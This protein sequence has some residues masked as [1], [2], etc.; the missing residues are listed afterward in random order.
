MWFTVVRVDNRKQLNNMKKATFFLL[1]TSTFC[2]SQN[3]TELKKLD[4]ILKSQKKS[5]VKKKI[6]IENQISEIDKKIEINKS[7]I[8][9]QNLKKRLLKLP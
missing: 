5:L 2:F 3:S 9:V 7:K 8:T 1:L 6:N 4:E